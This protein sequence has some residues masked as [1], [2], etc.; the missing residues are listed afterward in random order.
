MSRVDAGFAAD[1]LLIFDVEP[2]PGV[3]TSEPI[4]DAGQRV[5]EALATT[6]GVVSASWGSATTLGLDASRRGMT[7]VTG[8]VVRHWESASPIGEGKER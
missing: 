3:R 1:H 5:R 2:R 6:G 4:G 8:Q 7:V